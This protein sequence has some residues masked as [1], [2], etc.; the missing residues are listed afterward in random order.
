V[1]ARATPI[2]TLFADDGAEARIVA[3]RH[4]PFVTLGASARRS[5]DT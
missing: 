4:K 2:G 5:Y 3:T 1:A